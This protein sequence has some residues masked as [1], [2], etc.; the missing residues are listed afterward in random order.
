MNKSALVLAALVLFSIFGV[1]GMPKASAAGEVVIAVDL[2]HGE[3]PQG[4]DRLDI[5]E[6]DTDRG[7]A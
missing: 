4:I 3:N 1:F 5:Q 2:A 7:N 6:R